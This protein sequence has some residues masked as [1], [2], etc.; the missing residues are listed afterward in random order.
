[1]VKF[2]TAAFGDFYTETALRGMVR[3]FVITNPGQHLVVYVDKIPDWI[4]SIDIEVKLIPKN[5]LNRIEKGQ[6]SFFELTSFKYE[7]ISG[8]HEENVNDDIVWIDSDSLVLGELISDIQF[9]KVGF[10]NHGSCSDDEVFDC[11]KGLEVQGKD[12]AIGGYFHIPNQAI[13]QLL[14]GLMK[15]RGT[16]KEDKSAYWYN[17]GEQSLLNHVV[18]GEGIESY[19]I[20]KNGVYNWN[21]LE[22][23]HPYPLDKGLAGI[24]KKGSNFFTKE[25]QEIK[26]LSWSSLTLRRHSKQGYRSLD[27][28]VSEFFRD[29]FYKGCP[30]MKNYYA[31]NLFLAYDYFFSP[32]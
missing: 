3:S 27:K 1:M 28:T 22:G 25:N 18:H 6:R 11:G 7:L 23:R 30:R 13:S 19:K 21:F 17:D 8:L 5:I 15:E 31:Q 4:N 29:K 9:G 14:I 10:I 32:R 26:L 20:N 24:Y 16:W 2:L 12:F